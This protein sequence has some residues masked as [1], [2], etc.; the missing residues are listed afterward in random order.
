M[1]TAIQA[2]RTSVRRAFTLIELL[3]VIAIIALLVGILLPAIGKARLAGQMAKSLVNMRSMAMMNATYAGDYQGR[4]VNPFYAGPSDAVVP[5]W[6]WYWVVVPGTENTTPGFF[7]FE[8][9]NHLTEMLGPRAGS[10]LTKYHDGGFQSAAQAAPMDAAVVARNRQFNQDINSQG[11]PYVGA[12]NDYD[13]VI[14]DGSYW[15]SPTLWLSPSLY[16]TDMFPGIQSGDRGRYSRPNRIDD[17]VA[18]SAK[19]IVWERFDFTK[20]SHAAGTAANP[21]QRRASGFPNWNNPDADARYALSDG[22]CGQIHMAKLYELAAAPD[23]QDVYKPAGNW[24]IS[25]L[26][27]WQLANDGLQNGV[28]NSPSGPGGPF[29]AFFWA[30]R[31]GIQGRDI[32]R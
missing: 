32:N 31:H 5:G 4:N 2:R 19:V 18:P 9:P 27:R 28:P 21:N 14:Y 25:T 3:V 23:T 1:A 12:G 24:D 17:F 22:S 30:T 8:D 13:T 10:L 16:S 15:F 26:D 11:G 20:N 6:Y 7:K 29:P